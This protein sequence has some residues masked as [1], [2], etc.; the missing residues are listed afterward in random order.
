MKDEVPSSWV[1]TDGSHWQLTQGGAGDSA[2]IANSP[3]WLAGS[4][5]GLMAAVNRSD[6]Q[7]RES[8]GGVS[9]QEV[10]GSGA[11]PAGLSNQAQI[12]PSSKGLLIVDPGASESVP[13]RIWFATGTPTT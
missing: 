5:G 7:V 6:G 11:A 3:A 12:I 1:A 8:F 10:Q 13:A 9:W 2:S 4:F